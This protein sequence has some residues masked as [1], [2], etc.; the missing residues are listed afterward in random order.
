MHALPSFW[1][2]WQTIPETASRL[3]GRIE[4]VLDYA[5]AHGLRSGENPAAWR[6]HLALILPKRRRLSHGH[7]AAMA[8]DELPNFIG[9]LRE[10]NSMVAVAPEF[11]IL[12]AARSGEALGAR[13]GEIDLDAAIWTI[14]PARMKAGKEHRVPLSSAAVA[15]L[16]NVQ[17]ARSG[18]FVF[19]G[20]SYK[21][22]LSST[23]LLK[24]LKR[25]KIEGA[26]VHGFRSAFRDWAGNETN[27]PR[28]IA[29]TALAHTVGNA[30]E[31]A[32]RRSDAL[33][34]RRALMEAWA[35][36]CEPGAGGNVIPIRTAL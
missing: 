3:R 33:E 7:H 8:Y 22:T 34:K 31:A 9:Q 17:D 28:E 13:W 21:A 2:P 6:G 26:T 5:K 36:Y 15:I 11:L 4:T 23:A 29:E 18:D 12:T 14:P 10:R 24:V 32:Y 35:A 19:P 27:F 30:V 20:Q 16:G 1:R 25:M